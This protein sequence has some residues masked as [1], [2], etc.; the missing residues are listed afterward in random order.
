M[1]LGREIALQQVKL[2]M[3]KVL[4]T[5][6]MEGVKGMDKNFDDDFSLHAMWYRP[7][8]WVRFHSVKRSE[9]PG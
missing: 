7:R 9:N 2:F 3:A 6:N 1:C 4:W 5:F 8:I